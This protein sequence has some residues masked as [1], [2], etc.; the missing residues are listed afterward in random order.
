MGATES[1]AFAASERMASASSWVI[2]LRCS[3]SSFGGRPKLGSNF[4]T[5]IVFE[6]KDSICSAKAL[7]KPWMIETM[8][9][10]VTTP[11]ATPRIVSDE[12]SLFALTVETAIAADSLISSKLM[13]DSFA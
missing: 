13:A 12:R 2:S 3:S 1:T 10:S 11:I 9:V 8:K 5:K 6:P 7:F 4:E